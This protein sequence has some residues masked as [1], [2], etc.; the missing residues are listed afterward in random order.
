[1]PIS[2]RPHPL[3][4]D[5]ITASP[6]LGFG[7]LDPMLDTARR[8]GAGVFVLALTSNKEGPEVQH[9]TS[10]DGRSVA[11]AMLDH[12]RDLNAGD[13]PLGS[14]GAV[15]GATIGDHD[16]DLAINGPLLAPG[17]GAQ[18]GTVADLR[19]IFGSVARSVLASTSRDLLRHGPDAGS[20]GRRR[21]TR[22]RRARRAAERLMR[23][24]VVLPAAVGVLATGCAD[25]QERY[26]EAVEERQAELSEQVAGGGP[27]ALIDGLATLRG[28]GRGGTLRHPRRV[29]AADRPRHR[30]A[31]RARR[32]R[33]RR[34][35]V[36]RG[37]A[38]RRPRRTPTR[39][40]RTGGPRPGLRRDPARAGRPR[41]AGPRRVPDATRGV[42]PD[43][44]TSRPV[45][46]IA[47]AE[48]F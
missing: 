19:R 37:A 2:T 4:S 10:A 8:H 6:Y 23:R 14:F 48:G 39:P 46:P 25:D 41:A 20:T 35:D 40:D 15:V 12:L 32:R 5:A 26:C 24:L 22:Q 29:V 34:G 33:G 13:E 44:Q 38:P 21:P 16:G 3:A 43:E 47:D 7:S 28:A 11:A 18:G 1:M 42:R 27:A 45:R 17:Y 36:R 9:A 31:R 30:P